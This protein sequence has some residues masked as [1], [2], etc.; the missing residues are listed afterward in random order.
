MAKEAKL[1]VTLAVSL[2]IAGIWFSLPAVS[3]YFTARG[4]KHWEVGE[5]RFSRAGFTTSYFLA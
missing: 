5:T 4:L 1:G 2:L 3:D